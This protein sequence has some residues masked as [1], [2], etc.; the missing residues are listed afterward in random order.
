MGMRLLLFFVLVAI[1]ILLIAIRLV[2]RSGQDRRRLS[3]AV[4]LLRKGTLPSKLEQRLV[5]EGLDRAT[6]A[7]IVESALRALAPLKIAKTRPPR[8]T[9]ATASSPPPDHGTPVPNTAESPSAPLPATPHERGIA[10]LFKRGDYV[11]ALE[12]FTQAIERDPLYPNAYFG[13]AL[14]HRRLGNVTAAL[15]DEQKAEELGGSEKTV[16]DRLVNRSRHRW[17]WDFDNADWKRTD[18][19][20]RQAV[21]FRTL[22][23]QIFNGGLIQWVANGYCRWIDDVIEAAR[24]V[25]TAATREVAAMLEELSRQLAA[26]SPGDGSRQRDAPEEEVIDEQQDELIEKIF[27]YE[28]RYYRV[29]S[30]F[31]DDVE[32]WLEEKA[33]HRGEE[34]S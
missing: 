18:P 25:D 3:R 8:R 32:K 24:E 17:Q 23:R 31:A 27:E 22:V 28:L 20:S 21:L 14:A 5:A 30:Q 13:R 11:G 1:L 2:M 29:E 4:D 16:W 12:A 26:V 34:L 10:L 6:A 33:A 19:L 15:E 7:D 9:A